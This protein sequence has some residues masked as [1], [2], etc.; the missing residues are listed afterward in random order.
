[1]NRKYSIQFLLI[2]FLAGLLYETAR[3]QQ[4][5]VIDQVTAV[6]GGKV[7][8]L[9]DIEKQ[10]NQYVIQGGERNSEGKC[11]VFDQLILQKLLINQAELDSVIVTDAQVDGELDKRMRFYVKQI[12]SEQK[13][14][15]YFHTTIVQLKAEL[16]D[17]IRDQLTVQ[18]MQGKITKDISST[19][20]EVRE[21]FEGIPADS[22]PYIDAELEVAQIVRKP[23]VS[24]EEKKRVKDQLDEYRS[25]IIGGADFAVYAALYSQDAASAKK[26]GELGFFE[27]RRK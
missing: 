22:I 4:S 5:Q 18:V 11:Q 7:I 12:G 15:E 23:P 16:R 25:K 17:L 24:Q 9:S 3:S 26:G 1:M 19:P 6:V 14:E 8:L 21:Y 27:R 10:F 13:L 2:F 20:N